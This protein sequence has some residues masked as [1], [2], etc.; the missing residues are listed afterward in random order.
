M[1]RRFA[2]FDA[3]VLLSRATESL[4]RRIWLKLLSIVLALIVWTY[5]INTT[6]SLTRSKYVSGLS[7]SISGSSVLNNYGLALASDTYAEYVSEIAATVD[8]SQSQFS[9]VTSKNIV[10]TLDISHIRSAGSHDVALNAVSAYGE[11]MK[12]YPGAITVV[13]ENLDSR[14]VPIHAKLDGAQA[15]E[16][17]YSVRTDTINPQQIS[18]SGP[19][20]IVQKVA[21][22]V[23]MVDV[24]G[25][26][27]SFRRAVM[28][29][30]LDTADGAINSRLLTKSASTCSVSVEVYPKKELDVS[31]DASQIQVA[32]GYVIDGISFQPS[33]I[34]V[35]AQ[36]ELLEDMVYL[37]LEISDDLHPASKTFTTRLTVSGLSEF[38]Y[39]SSTQVYMTVSISEIQET[40]SLSDVAIKTMGLMD[41]YTASVTPEAF[42][43]QVTGPR[44]L[45]AQ[46]TPKDVYAYVDLTDLGEGVYDLPIVIGNNPELSYASLTPSVAKVSIS[47]VA[48]VVAESGGEDGAE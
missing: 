44:S 48:E 46:L 9:K 34:T 31:M 7:V 30:M 33:T 16:Y 32:E 40:D 27:S 13:V 11:V 15:D 19:A 28:L 4:T 3:R 37:P 6:P 18:L 26:T 36:S 22:A 43:L 20:S 35:A 23:A 10:V 17:W 14:D 1:K 41:G 38:K 42:S 24:T 12:I 2:K 25:Q 47:S 45:I 39:V 21:R 29:N 5:I 8:V